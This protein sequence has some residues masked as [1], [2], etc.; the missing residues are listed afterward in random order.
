MVCSVI[1]GFA[2]SFIGFLS[3]LAFGYK[4][5]CGEGGRGE[6]RVKEA[7]EACGGGGRGRLLVVGMRGWRRQGHA[8]WGGAG[9]SVTWLGCSIESRCWS[10][11]LSP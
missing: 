1:L 3:H 6:H 2:Q 4:E 9:W 11:G 10:T 8:G 7:A 5:A